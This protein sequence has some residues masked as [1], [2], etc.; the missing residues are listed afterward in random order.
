MLQSVFVCACL[1]VWPCLHICVCVC[2]HLCHYTD[3]CSCWCLLH[4]HSLRLT[5]ETLDGE[6]STLV[7]EDQESIDFATTVPGILILVSKRKVSFWDPSTNSP[8]LLAATFGEDETESLSFE[9]DVV[10]LKVLRVWNVLQQEEGVYGCM[11]ALGIN[12]TLVVLQKKLR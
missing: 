4:P 2:M 8:Y 3:S 7:P 10:H 11:A 5:C 6:V 1:E 12:D 9:K